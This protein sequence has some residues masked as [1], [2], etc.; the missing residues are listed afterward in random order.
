MGNDAEKSAQHQIRDGEGLVPAKHGL[1][2]GTARFVF[3]SVVTIRRHQDTNVGQY[4]DS[5]P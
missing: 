2:P 3:R 1:E 4:H 5:L